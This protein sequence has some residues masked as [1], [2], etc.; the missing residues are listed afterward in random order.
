MAEA[1][2][3][4]AE[5]AAVVKQAAEDKAEAIAAAA[6]ALPEEPAAGSEGVVDVAVKMADGSRVRRRFLRSHPLQAGAFTRPLL[7]STERCAS[8]CIR[9]H[10]VPA[11][12]SNEHK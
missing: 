1:A 7:S 12:V 6:D 8:A 10:R 2:V 5:E 11:Y 4:A 3:V 9:R